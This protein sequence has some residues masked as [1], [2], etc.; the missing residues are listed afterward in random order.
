VSDVG[1][2]R[3]V[4]FLAG[5]L[6]GLAPEA[7]VDVAATA[8]AG[9]RDGSPVA[10]VLSL[11]GLFLELAARR[12]TRGRRS[13]LWLQGAL[14]G[15]GYALAVAAL[16]GMPPLL[17]GLLVVLLPCAALAL[18]RFDPRAAVA[19]LA[20]WA[21]RLSLVDLASLVSF[22]AEPVVRWCAMSAGVAL[23]WYVT[24]RSTTTI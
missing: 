2:D 20:F 4:G 19:V 22:E 6:P 10:E 12:Q 5:R 23:A 18:A 3:V 7:R 16:P 15:L 17:T 24:R 11:A 1:L 13:Q 21:W 9:A 14:A 8:R